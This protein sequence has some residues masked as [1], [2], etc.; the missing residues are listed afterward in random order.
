MK[1]YIIADLAS[2]MKKANTA[3]DFGISASSRF[4][5]NRILKLQLCHGPPSP[6][7]RWF[8]Q[9]EVFATTK[10]FARPV[11]FVVAGFN[12]RKLFERDVKGGVG[13]NDR[14]QRA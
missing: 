14:E 9:N 12:S 1:A 11:N 2:G 13:L 3:E 8:R 10:C 5:I 4:P 6:N 7:V